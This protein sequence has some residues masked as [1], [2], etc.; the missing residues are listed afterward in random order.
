MDILAGR[1]LSSVEF[2]H[3]YVQLRFDGPCLTAYVW[4]SLHVGG[5]TLCVDDTGYR[6]ALV[7]RIGAGVVAASVEPDVA[8]SIEFDDGWTVRVSLRAE[9]YGVGPE[10]AVLSGERGEPFDVW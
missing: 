7:G 5:V 2:V 3:D 9:D 4:P 1:S 10:A 6:D 8:I